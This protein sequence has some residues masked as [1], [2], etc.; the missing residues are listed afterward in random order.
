MKNVVPLH[1]EKGPSRP[2]R[3]EGGRQS[4]CLKTGP[5]TT[6]TLSANGSNLVL[7]LGGVSGGLFVYVKGLQS[8][9]THGD[10]RQNHPREV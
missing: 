5:Y 6:K 2:P 4:Q 7:P 10:V 1:R 3:G 9:Q 8:N